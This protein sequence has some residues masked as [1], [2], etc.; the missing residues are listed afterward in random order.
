[1]SKQEFELYLSLLSRFLRLNAGQRSEIS[2]ELRDHLEER[3]DELTASGLSQEAAI[4]Q[5]LDEFGDAAELATHFTQ[6]AHRRR[7]RIL[8]RCTLAS[9]AAASAVILISFAMWPADPGGNMVP[10]V[11]AQQPGA[12]RAGMGSGLGDVAAPE[13]TRDPQREAVETKL[14][15][16]I[17]ELDFDDIPLNDALQDI[18]DQIELDIFINHSSLEEEGINGD[19]PV[20]LKVNYTKLSAATAIELILERATG[21]GQ[22]TY[23]IRDG[24]IYIQTT[25]ASEDDLEIQVYNVRDILD[26]VKPI[27]RTVYPGISG[28]MGGGSG[29]GFFQIEDD[30]TASAVSMQLGGAAGGPGAGGGGGSAMGGMGSAI[31]AGLKPV[32]IEIP[33]GKVLI[34]VITGSPG[35]PW[36]DIDGDGGKIEEFDGLFVIRQTQKSHREIKQ[37]LDT[38]RAT[39][40]EQPKKR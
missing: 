23:S 6:L 21:P 16:K 38:L 35:G 34:D 30:I 22:L 28:G 1:M 7:R 24:L 5:A 11:V 39:A 14:A 26:G 4:R 20:T 29:G 17:E 37:L 8:M 25:E 40:K 27:T 36:M 32:T 33:A 19:E 2:D 9:I 18:A 3:L 13:S 15:T 31:A 12:G 10:R